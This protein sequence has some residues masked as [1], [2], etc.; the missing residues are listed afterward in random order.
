MGPSN[1]MLT[2][3][4]ETVTVHAEPSVSSSINNTSSCSQDQVLQGQQ[5]PALSRFTI[6]R[7]SLRPVTLEVLFL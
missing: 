1:V 3:W 4:T 5:E 7:A 2:N 6:L